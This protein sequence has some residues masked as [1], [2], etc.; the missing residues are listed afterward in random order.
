M[1][2]HT[3]TDVRALLAYLERICRYSDHTIRSYRT[4][5]K[6]YGDFLT[7]RSLSARTASMQDVL[8]FAASLSDKSPAT[9]RTR[10]AAVK[11]LH[12]YLHAM[13]HVER[14]AA[15]LVPVPRRIR[16]QRPS[17]HVDAVAS[18]RAQVAGH[19]D[20]ALFGLL[21]GSMLRISEVRHLRV[22]DVDLRRREVTVL[23]KGSVLR[24]VPIDQATASALERQIRYRHRPATPWVFPSHRAGHDGPISPT[25]IYRMLERAVRDAEATGR[26]TPH[27]LRR[28]MSRHLADAGASPYAIQS[29]LGHSSMSQSSEYVRAAGDVALPHGIVDGITD[30]VRRVR[31]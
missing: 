12:A 8:D 20:Q 25:P 9:A 10:I 30:H 15:R 11:C 6:Q 24:T 5:L 23:A 31:L 27:A 7:R 17:P 26:W 16:G 29:G 3:T 13:G 22:E 14:D 18:V 4:G 19:R 2:I 1:G 21:Y 28:A